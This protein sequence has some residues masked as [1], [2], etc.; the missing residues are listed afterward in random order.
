MVNKS[1]NVGATKNSRVK[2]GKLKLNKERVKDLSGGEK[3]GVK[4]GLRVTQE[5]FK[6]GR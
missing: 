3:R 4:G 1:K 2:V 6:P 5:T